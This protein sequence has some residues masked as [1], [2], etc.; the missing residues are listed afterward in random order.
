M[1]YKDNVGGLAMSARHDSLDGMNSK[2]SCGAFKGHLMMVG[3]II[4]FVAMFTTLDVQISLARMD[5]N[6]PTTWSHLARPQA[7][8]AFIPV[9]AALVAIAAIIVNF[10]LRLVLRRRLSRLAHW[11]CLGAAY[12]SVSVAQPISAIGI[13][14]PFVL[15][16]S[17]AAALL[18]AAFVAWR[19]G[20]PRDR[21][22]RLA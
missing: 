2:S 21:S 13:N 17:T 10:V 5:P 22:M 18:S 15:W 8:Y 19:Y 7:A 3:T 20:A 11:A 1:K 6:D 14:E 4:V 12:A 9:L 16:L